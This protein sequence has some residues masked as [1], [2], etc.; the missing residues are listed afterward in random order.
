MFQR[1]AGR[2]S[3]VFSALLLACGGGSDAVTTPNPPPPTPV[4][5]LG[6]P[7]TVVAYQGGGQTGEPSTDLG[8]RPAV[9]VKD[10]LNRVVPG[11]PVTFAVDSGGGS[12]AAGQATTGTD[13]VA[14]SG[15]WTLGPGEGRHTL[16]V[17]VGS[18]PPVKLAA[19]AVVAEVVLT[20]GQTTLSGGTITVVRP[21]SA[22]DKFSITVP[23]SAFSGA[24]SF[25]VRQRSSAGLTLSAPGEAAILQA[26]RASG[27]GVTTQAGNPA[28]TPIITIVTNGPAAAAGELLLRIPVPK[29]TANPQAA[30][31]DSTGIPLTFLP[32]L[33]RDSASITVSTR[34]LNPALLRQVGNLPQA[35]VPPH[36]L[37]I[38]IYSG[39][40]IGPTLSAFAPRAFG[41]SFVYGKNDL[42][43]P[44]IVTAYS[45]RIDNG[46]ALV[47]YGSLFQFAGGV[48]HTFDRAS[49]V[50]RSDTRGIM[51][52]AGIWAD[53][54]S[55]LGRYGAQWMLWWHAQD[56]RYDYH[57]AEAVLNMLW[58]NQRPVPLWLT[59]GT[60]LKMVLVTDWDPAGERF[61]VRDAVHAVPRYL[62]FAGGVMAPYT[63]GL[64]ATVSYTAPYFSYGWLST[65]WSHLATAVTDMSSASAT[66]RYSQ[67][68]PKTQVQSRG[69]VTLR[70]T[71]DTP[72]TVYFLA[73]TTRVWPILQPAT[74]LIPTTLPIT[75]GWGLA[76]ARLYERSDAG[77]WNTQA[78]S[79]GTS[80]FLDWR[81]FPNGKAQTVGVEIL[82]YKNAADAFPGWTGWRELRLIKY[83]LTV[84]PQFKDAGTPSIFTPVLA[85]GSPPLP[86]NAKFEWDF[87]DGTPKQVV[88]SLI[89]VNHTYAA[90]GSFDVVLRVLHSGHSDLPIA[91]VTVNGTVSANVWLITS[92]SDPDSLFDEATDSSG[93]LAE[94]LRRLLA[95]PSSSILSI[96]DSASIPVLRLRVLRTAV[97]NPAECCPP[98]PH[99]PE[100]QMPLGPSIPQQ[101]AFG[102]FFSAW[103]TSSFTRTATT[104][105]AQQA[106]GPFITYSVKDA[107]SQLGPAGGVRFTASINGL[108]M[109][110]TI[111][112]SIIFVDGTT[113][114]VD[115][116]SAYRLP[117][118]AT[119][120]R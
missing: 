5:P 76:G 108:T 69:A 23:D 7:A 94:L 15:N 3:I 30:V 73:D 107:G 45:P 53:A 44:S 103:R 104:I 81:A 117:F 37:S 106:F 34:V 10:S 95:V 77:V 71:P 40:N 113:G 38:V 64:D 100:L 17:T 62:S 72:D 42:A 87:G 4:A 21:G 58:Y 68:F 18:L 52:S 85:N 110:G 84:S 120:M 12:I 20:T 35:T 88:T 115:G 2:A 99:G 22:L 29:G 31:V 1:I 96:E 82:E 91:R 102:P 89:A 39:P 116:E 92:I 78:S 16:R 105:Q 32:I 111:A 70:S 109:N 86:S 75:P 56:T 14:T 59:D 90:G 98:V 9:I 66:E 43:Y 74:F 50:G 47:E 97:W 101:H 6:P 8:I 65:F 24:V 114:I 36:A 26:I 48:Y 51:T 46:M 60:Y 13:G 57:I 93:P 49:G 112:I 63:D 33:S 61:I 27:G 54:F 28:V 118:T 119:R 67:L 11:A 25:T 55:S 41:A 19:I 79:S 83:G 80:F